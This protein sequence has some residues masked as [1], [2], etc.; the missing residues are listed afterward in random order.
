M[1]YWSIVAKMLDER[2]AYWWV[3]GCQAVKQWVQSSKS[4]SSCRVRTGWSSAHG[5]K[6]QA[7]N[8]WCTWLYIDECLPHGGLSKQTG[9]HHGWPHDLIWVND[10]L[11]QNTNDQWQTT[12]HGFFPHRACTISKN[13]GRGYG[14]L[15]SDYSS[16]ISWGGV[17]GT[18]IFAM[19]VDQLSPQAANRDPLRQAWLLWLWL[20][21]QQWSHGTG[22]IGLGELSSVQLDGAMATKNPISMNKTSSSIACWSSIMLFAR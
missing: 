1:G 4:E 9:C 7:P 20:Q 16:I 11:R 17:V 13:L 14:G 5:I 2:M 15:S 6:A 22:S 21:L 10:F 3:N 18:S 12:F 19:A 8:P